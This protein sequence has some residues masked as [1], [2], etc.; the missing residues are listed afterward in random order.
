METGTPE[1]PCIAIYS[2]DGFG[3]GHI[4][5]TWSTAWEIYHLRA[6]ASILTFSP[7][8]FGQFFPISL[9]HDYIKFPS[10]AKDIPGNQMQTAA[11]GHEF[12]VTA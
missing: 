3:R 4:Q 10:L 11:G 5:P 2:Q 1:G 8:Q 6:E 9:H 12:P 7:S